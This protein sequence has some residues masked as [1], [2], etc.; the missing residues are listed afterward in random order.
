MSSAQTVSCSFNLPG[1]TLVP[2]AIYRKDY[3]SHYLSFNIDSDAD[4]SVATDELTLMEA[5]NVYALP[6]THNKITQVFPQC[7]YLHESSVEIELALRLSR[8]SRKDSVFLFF[9]DKFFRLLIIQNDQLQLANTFQFGS[10]M[11]VAYYVLYVLDQLN[12]K[13]GETST[14]AAGEIEENGAELNML[15]EYIGPVKLLK[16][17]PLADLKFNP[18]KPSD[19]HRLFTLFHQVLCV[20]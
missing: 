19:T 12:I 10:E 6:E 5:R 8:V 20:S 4:Q 7:L 18:E 3:Q 1:N 16:E 2:E 15:R 14:Y 9:S 13:N 11:D 17:S